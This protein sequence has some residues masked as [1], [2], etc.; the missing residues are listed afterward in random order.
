M[1]E[2]Q[3]GT[4]SETQAPTGPTLEELL[5]TTFP[6]I[7]RAQRAVIEARNRGIHLVP[8]E[9]KTG[10]SGRYKL[11]ECGPD[12]LET[13]GQPPAPDGHK[14]AGKPAPTAPKAT[15]PDPIG[16]SGTATVVGQA[17]LK[18]SSKPRTEAGTEA[19]PRA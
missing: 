19:P 16:L 11:R 6:N 8:E 13:Y 10:S 12:G 3:T 15:G 4:E 1:T 17:T 2:P 5:A 9:I 7:R 14:T 18:T